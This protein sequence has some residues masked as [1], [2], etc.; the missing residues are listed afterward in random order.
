VAKI[1]VAELKITTN[2]VPR[3]KLV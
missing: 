1:K 3:L 2:L